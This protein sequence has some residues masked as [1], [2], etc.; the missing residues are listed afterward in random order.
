MSRVMV[1]SADGKTASRWQFGRVPKATHL[2]AGHKPRHVSGW[3]LIDPEGYERFNEGT[4]EQ[5]IPFANR[6][7]ENYGF[8]P[9]FS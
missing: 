5:F 4:W 8:Q 2:L 3:V 9:T 6:V 1:K 7:L